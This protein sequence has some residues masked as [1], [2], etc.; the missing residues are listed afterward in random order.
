MQA[1]AHA[2]GR[3]FLS[4]IAAECSHRGTPITRGGTRMYERNKKNTHNGVVVPLGLPSVSLILSLAESSLIA[5]RQSIY[6]AFGSVQRTAT[7][8]GV[9]M[10][11]G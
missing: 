6:C 9:A 1:G 8:L 5:S 4:L 3:V 2:L 10:G 11:A 7:V